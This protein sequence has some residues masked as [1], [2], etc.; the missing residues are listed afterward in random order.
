MDKLDAL[1]KKMNRITQELHNNLELSEDMLTTT[2][3]IQDLLDDIH[4]PSLIPM[5]IGSQNRELSVPEEEE[6]ELNIRKLTNTIMDAED[7]VD[8]FRYMRKTLRETTDNT[9]RVLDSI[10]DELILADEESRASLIMAY[11]ELN[12]SQLEGMKLLTQS[13]KEVSTI[14][15]NLSKAKPKEPNVSTTNI[16]N[17]EHI[18][19]NPTSA[20]DI[21]KS[22]RES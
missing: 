6:P 14:I 11:S 9:K 20:A 15:V 19:S 4:R 22:I 21:L 3:E 2:G 18:G 12:K 13:Y 17:V 8:D 1:S 10:T 16:L 5:A 7:M